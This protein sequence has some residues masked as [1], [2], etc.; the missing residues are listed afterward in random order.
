MPKIIVSN[1]VT[2]DGYYEGKDRSIDVLF[3]YYH[4]DYVGDQSFDH[5]NAER[6]RAADT[7]LLSG[8]SAFL[9]N[10]EYWL[11]IVDNPSATPIRRE[12]A[13]LMTAIDKVVVSDKL[14]AAELAPW[15]NTRIVRLPDAHDELAALKRQEG[16]EILILGG[17][18]LWHDLLA[19]DLIDELHFTFFP[20]IAGEGTP[21]F[22]GQPGVILKLVDTRTWEGSGNILAR[23]TVSRRQL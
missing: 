21:L 3:D 8:R 5:Y 2:L 1:F 20:L 10:K 14:T 16:G 18:T 11:S 17:R 15:D 22:D 6:L 9:G 19:H 12:I 7:W 23:Y 4:E 13:Q